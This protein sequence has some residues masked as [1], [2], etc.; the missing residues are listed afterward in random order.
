VDM[1][2]VIMAAAVDMAAVIMAVLVAGGN[3][4]KYTCKLR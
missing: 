1:A 3:Y 4:L 2:A